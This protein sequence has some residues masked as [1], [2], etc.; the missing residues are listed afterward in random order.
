MEWKEADRP[1]G[2]GAFSTADVKTAVDAEI[3][4]MMR[5]YM[6]DVGAKAGATEVVVVR[7]AAPCV[8]SNIGKRIGANSSHRLRT[9]GQEGAT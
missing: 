8:S 6:Q 3:S 2:C 7:T 9:W 4:N 1:G 5:K